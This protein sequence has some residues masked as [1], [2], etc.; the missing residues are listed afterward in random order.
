MGPPRRKKEG[1]IKERV[2]TYHICKHI[3]HTKQTMLELK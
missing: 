2:D 3:N 1:Q